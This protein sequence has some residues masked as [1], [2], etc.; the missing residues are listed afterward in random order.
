MTITKDE[1]EYT[2]AEYKYYWR[3][4]RKSGGL[5]VEYKI[6]KNICETEKDLCE[7]IK[8]ENIF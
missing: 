3:V 1:K 8:S 7:Y 6:N 2:I 5:T 4:T